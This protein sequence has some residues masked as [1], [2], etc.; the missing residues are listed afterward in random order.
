MPSRCEGS[1]CRRY[2]S[3]VTR[4][5]P[6][7]GIMPQSVKCCALPNLGSFGGQMEEAVELPGRQRVDSRPPWKQ[8]TLRA[9]LS[10]ESFFDSTTAAACRAVPAT[11]SRIDPC[12][13]RLLNPDHHLSAV[14]VADFERHDFGGAQAAAI[15]EAQEQAALEARC[16]IEQAPHFRGTEH[17]SI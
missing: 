6:G 15:G 8:P 1:G 12:D 11:A 16:G 9:K 5:N 2:N 4:N 7:L 3:Q 14:D 13:L 17:D 10:S